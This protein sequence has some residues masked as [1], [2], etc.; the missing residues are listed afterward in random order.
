MKTGWMR[1]AFALAFLPVVFG[2][3]GCAT[4]TAEECAVADWERLGESDARAGRGMDHF[5]RRSGDCAEA[6]YRADQ[7][8]WQRGWD[9]GIVRFC[10]RNNGFRQGLEGYR[11]EH[12][13]PAHLEEDF[14]A[15]YDTGFAIHDLQARVE[16]T[17]SQIDRLKEQLQELRDERPRDREEIADVR[18]RLALLHDRL[19]QQELELARMKGVAQGQGFPVRL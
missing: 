15:G 16:N 10:T 19:R 2:L 11:Y 7:S 1:T 3:G 13:C 18:D 8:A 17:H 6:G 9:R 12:I 4:M 14:L 5:A